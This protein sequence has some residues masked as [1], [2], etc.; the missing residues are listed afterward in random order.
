SF[1]RADVFASSCATTRHFVGALPLL[2]PFHLPDYLFGASSLRRFTSRVAACPPSTSVNCFSS[3]TVSQNQL[4][5]ISA[6]PCAV[7][8]VKTRLHLFTVNGVGCRLT[9][10]SRMRECARALLHRERVCLCSPGR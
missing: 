10:L 3:I 6:P 2:A 5:R 9:C 7:P 8:C 4:P 1:A